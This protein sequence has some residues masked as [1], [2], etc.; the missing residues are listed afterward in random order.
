MQTSDASNSNQPGEGWQYHLLFEKL[1]T[2]ISTNFI[3]MA[4]EEIDAGII[5][6]LGSVCAY[7]GDDRSYVVLFSEDGL[8]LDTVYEWCA[9][10][11]ES[12]GYRMHGTPVSSMPWIIGQLNAQQ[13]VHIPDTGR[14]PPE[15]E[16]ECE[17]C[18]ADGV[19][20]ILMVPLVLRE[21]TMGYLGFEAIRVRKE[22]PEELI[23][24]LKIVSE[25]IVNALQRK[26][27]E[28]TLREYYQTLEKRVEER[29]HEIERRSQISIALR[30]ILKVLNSDQPLPEVLDY[31]VS[32]AAQLLGATATI[33]RRADV[34]RRTVTTDAGYNLPPEFE[35][36]QHTRLYYNANDL[37]L[38]SRRPVVIADIEATYRPVLAVT[39]G[40]DD[41][42]LT[43]IQT[44]VKYYKSMLSVPLFIKNEIYGSLNFY[45]AEQREFP[46]E[47]IQLALSLGDQAA[48]AIE[49]AR[50]YREERDRRQEADRRRKVA[51]SLRDT[52]AVLNSDL[53]LD[54]ILQHI[55]LKAVELL[56]A[57]AVA[58]YRL[59][60]KEDELV[61]RASYG[62][63]DEYVNQIRIPVGKGI[64]GHAITGGR[65][66]AVSDMAYAPDLIGEEA[67][68]MAEERAV[69]EKLVEDYRAFLSVPL[70]GKDV[71]YGAITLY[72]RGARNFTQDE[73]E[74]A[75]SF[76]D[77]ATLAIENARLRSESE[78]HAIAAER[79][80]LARDLHDAVTQTLFSA[81]LIAEVLPRIWERNPEEGRRRL[82]ELRQL[83]RGA[84]AE[85]RTLLL[86]LRPTALTEGSLTDLLRQLA[87][88]VN[89]RSRLPVKL[90]VEGESS[91]AP[92]VQVALYRI[93]QEALNNIIK[94]SGADQATIVLRH[95]PGRVNDKGNPEKR[96]ELSIQDNGHGFDPARVPPNHFG[97]GIMIERA[98]SIN[99]YLRI[100]SRPR[101]GTKITV[102]WEG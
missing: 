93:A 65:P 85:M 37:I 15:A 77:Q 54:E 27:T 47:S 2:T 61:I 70:V 9:E 46:E 92:D 87:D 63:S 13:G 25:I 48:L 35:V 62:L 30:D 34:E 90:N 79:N 5:S 86:E 7:T 31:V 75:V 101:R 41:V 29:T 16:Q 66:V 64:A 71:T 32:Q 89:S 84:L 17:A 97:L 53:A 42:Q 96:V 12:K 26:R 67:D 10:G 56:N 23:V 39:E 102:I 18:R 69:L 100:D 81:S 58:I 40:M 94:H 55:V 73:I 80:R 22:W 21:R 44:L 83:S 28:E 82:E 52:M 45:F 24:L 95:L 72:Y 38:M 20:S 76:A 1:I 74:L 78:Q 88:A 98:Q 11:M 49:N 57:E 60:K 6:S 68:L 3:N 14:L 59:G 99:A 91:L 33:I 4:V 50:L 43:Y 51:E 36:I 8:A 19:Q